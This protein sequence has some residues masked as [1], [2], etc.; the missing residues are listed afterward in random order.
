[1]LDVRQFFQTT[2]PARTLDPR[3]EGDRQLYID[4]SEVRG[5]QIIAEIRDLITFYEPENPTC[6]LFT[7]HIGCGKSTELLKLRAELEEDEFHV[8]YFES[9]DDLEM[10][11]VDIGDVLLAIAR[12]ISQSL[13]GINIGEAKGLK[14]ILQGAA[15]ILM[16]EIELEGQAEIMGFGASANSEGEFS[17]SA[18]IGKITARAKNDATLRDR[19]N[20]FLGPQKNQLL[21]AINDEL[22]KPAIAQLQQQGKKGLVVIVDNL[23]RIDK[24]PK[25]FGRSQQEYLFIDQ[26]ECLRNL[27]CHKVYT[28]PLAL[29]FSSE[30][31]LLTA[32]YMDDPKVLPMVPVQARGGEISEKSMVLLRQLVLARALPG[33]SEDERLAAIAELFDSPETLDRLCQV[34]GGHVRDLLRLLNGWIRKQRQFPLSRDALESTI[35]SRRNEMTLQ[36]SDEEW[37]LLRQVRER[38]RVGGDQDYQMLIHSRLVFEYRDQGESWFDVNP[39]LLGSEGL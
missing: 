21:E 24:R 13:E 4:F 32:R 8:V 39:I 31:G 10:A 11:D 35:R 36:L 19:L 7:G 2:N 25:A 26:H 38:R 9:T 20:Q 23:D 28:M 29:K 6:T 1:M 17:V 27:H 16:T 22:L 3:R 37:A 15:R 12:R 14:G 30:Y 18:G 5:E 34:S 33:S